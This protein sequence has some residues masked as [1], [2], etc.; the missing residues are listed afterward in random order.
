MIPF[1]SFRQRLQTELDVVEGAILNLWRKNK[2]EEFRNDP[3]S[4]V[5]IMMPPYY[6]G[7]LAPEH[8]SIQAK[9]KKQYEHWHELFSRCHSRHSRDVKEEIKRVGKYV[10]CAIEFTSDWGIEPTFE[11]NRERLSRE[12]GQF[13][14]LLQ[15]QPGNQDEFILVPDTNALL[16]SADPT[17]Y[18]GII[19]SPR[20]TFCIVPTVLSELDG[21]KRKRQDQP[22]GEKAEKAIR[23]IKGLRHQGPMQTGVTV[24]KTITVRMIATEPRMS[25]LPSWL[26]LSSQDDKILASALEIQ[27]DD[28]AVIVILVTGDINLQNKAEMAFLPYA[29]PPDVPKP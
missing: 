19:N 16:K 29:E 24:A 17:P 25:D 14:S 18:Q 21:L 22:L 28:P 10:I 1:E 3:S 8:R 5:F 12:L 20:F 26:D 4:G 15:A 11:G 9:V 23:V 13:R 7:S 27:F 6:W 2:I